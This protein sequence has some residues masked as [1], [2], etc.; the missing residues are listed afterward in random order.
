MWHPSASLPTQA[1]SN[2]D[3]F[4]FLSRH[5]DAVRSLRTVAAQAAIVVASSAL[6]LASCGN[7]PRP[8]EPELIKSEPEPLYPRQ[9][10]SF[11][12]TWDAINESHWDTDFVSGDWAAAKTELRPK[13]VAAQTEDEARE[14]IRELLRRTKQSHFALMASE[15]QSSDDGPPSGRGAA[16][17]EIRILGDDIVVT[18]LNPTGPAAK[19]GVSLGWKLIRVDDT[20]LTNVL[21]KYRSSQQDAGVGAHIATSARLMEH[22]AITAWL[23]GK[24]D[25]DRVFEF[26]TQN[27]TVKVVIVL[28][29]PAGKL[30]NFGNLTD[31]PVEYESRFL[32]KSETMG[33]VRLSVFF[34]PQR[35]IGGFRDDVK[36]FARAKGLVLDFRGNPGGIGGM[37]TGFAN[38]IISDKGK[39]LGTMINRDSE[40]NFV[41]NPQPGAYTGKVAVLVDELCGSTCEIIAG[42]L[43]DIGRARVFGQVTAGV[44]LPSQ[45]VE[46]PS[47]DLLQYAT[48]NYISDSGAELEGKGVTPDEVVVLD[49]TQ[50]LNGI[51]SQLS[52][53]IDWIESGA[54]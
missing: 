4:N 11:D 43:A 5:R 37:S 17:F 52:A 32:D 49:R 47:G 54:K 16:G 12:Y 18:R 34:D 14:V 13:V 10:K 50:L 44:A 2:H 9:V 1:S 30:A 46:L 15:S 22:R 27:E 6:V 26:V 48:A 28:A 38:W 29:P 23:G 35:V 40:L 25:A 19:S 7:T 41:V 21:K 3:V 51:D 39:K 33:Y 8:T 45:I 24:I 53:A 36:N 31:I 42:G 20:D